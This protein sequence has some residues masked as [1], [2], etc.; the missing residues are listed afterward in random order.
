MSERRAPSEV[1][2]FAKA[3][4]A[5]LA[6]NLLPVL[7]PLV[8][9]VKALEQQNRELQERALA[10]EARLLELDARRVTYDNDV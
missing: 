10:A 8:A 3:Q 5:E 9:R 6:A 4:H 2:V 1:Y 7:R